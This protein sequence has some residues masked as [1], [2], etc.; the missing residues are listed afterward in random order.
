MRHNPVKT[1]LCCLFLTVSAV[2]AVTDQ[3]VRNMQEAMPEKPVV[4]PVKQRTMLVFSLCKG[5]AHSSIP[6]WAKALDVMAEKT[7]AFKVVHS[8]DM[9]VFTPE[10]LKP[11]DVICLNNTTGLV[12]DENQQQA[13][14]QFVMSGK[15]IVG[16]HAAT[17][18]FNQWPEGMEMMG[19]VFKGHPWG[20]GGT[21]AIKI[22]DPD[23]PLM[24]SFNGQ[25]F[26][27]KDE[28]YRTAPPLYSRDKQRVLMSLDMSDPTTKNA[29]GVEPDDMDTG[30]SWIK[31]VGG[32][33]LFYCSLGHDHAVTWNPAVLA[34]YLAGIQYAMGDLKVDDGP[35]K[36]KPAS[37]SEAVLDDLVQQLG[38][39]DWNKSR[40][41]LIQ[42]Q[43]LVRMYFDDRET[44][45][46]I[47]AKLL[48]VLKMDVSLAAK[49]FIGRQLALFGTEKAVPVLSEMLADGE[50]TN[51]ARY[52]LEQIP[53][54]AVDD[55][56]VRVAK[57]VQNKDILMGIITSLGHRKS[58]TLISLS[59]TVFSGAAEENGG[60]RD[61]YIEALGMLGTEAAADELLRIRPKLAGQSRLR[62][63]D[64]LLM[65]ADALT[66]AGRKQP[67]VSIYR[68]LYQIENPP[69]IRAA[70]L[71]GLARAGADDIQAL[72]TKA[73]EM[74]DMQA[75][76]I[77]SLA[78]VDNVRFLKSV[79]A[80]AE[81]FSEPAT[82]QLLTVLSDKSQDTAR[83]LAIRMVGSDRQTE[84]IAAYQSLATTGDSSVVDVLASAAGQAEDRNE[85][86]AAQNA[87]YRI[88]GK[89]VDA[90][91]LAKIAGAET[92]GLDEK[93]VVEL[94][95]AVVNRQSENAMDVLFK[96]A[97][98]NNRRIAGESIRAIQSLAG[99][100]DA[101]KLI[102]LLIAMPGSST[103]N[104]L[105]VLADRMP[106]RGRLTNAVMSRY[107]AVSGN[108]DARV[109][110][111][112]VLGRLGEA[113]AVRLIKRE[114]TSANEKL[115]EAAFRAMTDWRGDDFIDEMKTLAQ[116]APDART[117]IVGFR[118]YVRMV[119]ESEHKNQQ[120]K[121]DDLIAAYSL[122]ERPDERKIIIGS[123]GDFGSAKAFSFVKEKLD[124]PAL[125][126]EAGVSLMQISE[127]LMTRNPSAVVSVLRELKQSDP[128]ESIQKK[129]EE[130]IAKV[131][132]L[133]G[134][135]FDWLVSGPYMEQGRS[136]EALFD[137]AF[138]PEENSGSSRWKDA[139]E[140]LTTE[141]PPLFDLSRLGQ[142]DDRVAYLKTVLS[143]DKTMPVVFQIGSDDGVK[144]WVGGKQVHANNVS[145]PV[146]PGQD[147]VSVVLEK[148]QN[149]ILVKVTQGSGGWGFCMQIT[150][151]DG[152]PASAVQVDAGN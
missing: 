45:D 64:A 109:S 77:Q 54:Q 130:L 1:I 121:V 134:Y 128:G 71:T 34:H 114:Y 146:V 143:V 149:P 137:V 32:G 21:W 18:N 27:I 99:P 116:T 97:R 46:I 59:Q 44:L 88:P 6:Y 24:A 113:D 53:G 5:Y 69:I 152:N 136:G 38:Q 98:S 62:C 104:A 95:N 70:A 108:D 124:D 55:A 123:L 85:R 13:I 148:G 83:L 41:A 111:L 23:H 49:D 29:E 50:T 40:A 36:A 66:R 11:F 144:V 28:I 8:E 75:A 89:A 120:Q 129:A 10:S 58:R 139:Q 14:M 96:A 142:G 43:N 67:A 42:L 51:I 133:E 74:D 110:L 91:I 122:A 105:I 131:S 126:A 78:Y 125:Q 72:L 2:F 101:A 33:R 141:N 7:G 63:D 107:A 92:S 138:A 86:T 26:K 37:L 80:N 3:E 60:T 57:T 100:E 4:E 52:A 20:G 73:M 15:G 140:L 94:I 76:A 151:K 119:R 16:I 150:D 35:V 90:A 115:S 30:I 102:D 103:E 65:N 117:K 79:V 118:A 25:G 145:R 93:A 9:N 19:G 39:Y 47:E 81:G 112:R 17:D 56:F 106:A 127:K 61:A 132:Q 68:T 22:D 87:L 135:V 82:I 48:V 84:R 31:P 147:K 12:P